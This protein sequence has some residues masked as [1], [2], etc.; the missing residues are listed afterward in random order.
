MW[1]TVLN[2]EKEVPLVD[3]QPV[4]INVS[5]SAMPQDIQPEKSRKVGV[6]TALD[7]VAMGH[8]G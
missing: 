3:L 5:G 7:D 6:H 2:I 1:Y 4:V 8:D